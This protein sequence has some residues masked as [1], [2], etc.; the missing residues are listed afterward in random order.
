MAVK[1]NDNQC[2]TVATNF[3]TVEPL[4]KAKRWSSA[5]KASID[6]PQPAVVHEYNL[7][8]GGVDILDRFMS[9]YRPVFR[10]KKWWWPLF[11]N[12]LNMAVV[13]AWRLHVEA[14]E[15]C[16]H[17]FLFH[18]RFITKKHYVFHLYICVQITNEFQSEMY[19]IAQNGQYVFGSTTDSHLICLPSF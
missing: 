9:N 5:K 1:W 7:H 15:L 17:N 4:H 19:N 6:L 13:A 3:S 14:S 8:M 11:I 18:L 12:G 10:S 16:C 2:V